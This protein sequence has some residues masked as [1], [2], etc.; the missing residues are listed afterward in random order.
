MADNKSKVRSSTK[1]WR[2]IVKEA[3]PRK[4]EFPTYEFSNS[5][6]FEKRD[7]YA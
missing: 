4:E 3:D 5:R 7:P 1:D 2:S 6:K